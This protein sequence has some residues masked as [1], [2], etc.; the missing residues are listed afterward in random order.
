MKLSDHVINAVRQLDRAIRVRGL[1]H[2]VGL[3]LRVLMR[4]GPAGI[5]KRMD[6][7]GPALGA[8]RASGPGSTVILT[9]PHTL[10]FARRLQAIL[11]EAGIEA[12]LSDSDRAA[13]GYETVFA[14]ALQN[15]PAVPAERCIAFQVEQSVLPNRW[16]PEYLARLAECRAVLEYSQLNIEALGAH[17]PL[18]RVFYVPL[19]P[20][21]AP[22]AEDRPKNVLFYG[23][24]SPQRRKE[25][26]DQVAPAIPELEVETNLFGPRMSE[27]L[28]KSAIVLNIHARQGGLLEVARI[29]EAMAHG[30]VIVS[31]ISPDQAQHGLNDRVVFVPE[32]D[33]PAMIA[34]LRRLLDTPDILRSQ[35][36]ASASP[37]PDRFR[38]GVL[39]A[40]QGLGMIGPDQFDQLAADYPDPA[41]S[42]TAE[43]PRICLSLPETPSRIREFHAVNG[44][45]FQV[46]PGLKATPGWRGAA[47]SY[48][49]L[50][51]RLRDAK[52]TEALIVEDDAILPPDFDTRLATI[53]HYMDECDA[54][55]FSGVI[56]DLHE[57]AQ[58]LGVRRQDGLCLVQ[59][60]RAVSMVANLYRPRMID[61]LAEWDHQDDNA[62]TNTIDRYMERATHLRVVTTLPFTVGFGRDAQSTL[63]QSDNRKYD[64]ILA[65]S[66][67]RLARKVAAFETDKGN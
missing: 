46:W 62:F 4:E 52:I 22:T 16:T 53:Q 45:G 64:D 19:S 20:A 11:S 6:A 58:V 8:R 7:L 27:R 39:R 54:D 29:S 66:E 21:P 40:L 18:S 49:Y 56:A 35:Q 63:R 48:R 31:E 36:I 57:D 30:C 24:A 43:M 5:R 67:A 15:F 9:V 37:M 44:D 47:L 50:M 17:V 38:L 65:R 32:G 41:T 42:S 12:D 51:R 34:A 25:L 10:H 59:L 60:D 23:D 28:G 61:W 3:A 2:T 14:F 13:A 55:M 26:L 1:R 33:A